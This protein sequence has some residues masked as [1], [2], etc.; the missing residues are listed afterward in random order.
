MRSRL[1]TIPENSIS[2][3]LRDI[4]CRSC[5]VV[6]TEEDAEKRMAPV[7]SSFSLSLF[8]SI[9]SPISLKQSG[10]ERSAVFWVAFTAAFIRWHG[11]AMNVSIVLNSSDS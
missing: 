8:S 4:V 9:R 5:T 10:S 1:Q 2:V 7:L 3:V 11:K 6:L